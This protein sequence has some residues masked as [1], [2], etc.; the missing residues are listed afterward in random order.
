M[1]KTSNYNLN[2]YEVNDLANLTDG[3]NN[4]MNTLDTTIKT[5]SNSVAAETTRATKAE[6][7]LTTNLNT[8]ITRAKAAESTLTTNL[9]AEVTRAKGA[10]STLTT[11]LNSEISRAKAAESTLTTNLNAEVTRAKAAE[12]E[13][14]ANVEKNKIA[15]DSQIYNSFFTVTVDASKKDDI[16]NFIFNTIDSALDYL[17]ANNKSNIKINVKN[18]T[19][20]INRTITNS[21][22]HLYAIEEN[23]TINA[24]TLNAYNSY[25]HF[26][27]LE[28][29]Y[30]KVNLSIHFDVGAL[31]MDYCEGTAGLNMSWAPVSIINSNL[32][33]TARGSISSNF[34]FSN[35]TVVHD[36]AIQCWNCHFS[37]KYSKVTYK[38]GELQ[39]SSVFYWNTTIDLTGAG[40]V[41]ANGEIKFQNC[42]FKNS[43]NRIMWTCV[44]STVGLTVSGLTLENVS[45]TK[46]LFQLSY[47]IMFVDPT[48]Y[49]KMT[50]IYS[51]WI[52]G[53]GI[54]KNTAKLVVE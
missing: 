16:D 28:T 5:V 36:G 17:Q 10:E 46:N 38:S 34:F 2:L 39:I 35:S 53:S 24:T 18:G 33:L 31:Y 3:Y 43:S 22:F 6:S 23:V 7:T 42:T 15:L 27:G 45:L 12:S 8:E 11:N 44:N 25:L 48:I 4:S 21:Q 26:E 47:S 30:L 19:Y 29:A 32:T 20:T 51:N 37:Y 50:A 1:K 9:N 52:G 13:I 49:N 54:V 14:E 40:S 41:R